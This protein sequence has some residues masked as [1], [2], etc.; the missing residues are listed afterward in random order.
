VARVPVVIPPNPENEQYL[1]TKR[2][3]MGHI[4]EEPLG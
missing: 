3:K 2:L 4:L 1:E